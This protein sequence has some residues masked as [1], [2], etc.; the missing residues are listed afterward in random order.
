MTNTIYAAVEP[1]RCDSETGINTAIGC[2]PFNDTNALLTFLLRWFIGIGGGIAIFTIIFASYLIISSSG[3]PDRVKAGQQLI[4]AS[5]AGIIF[6][7]FSGFILQ[8]VGVTVF[9]IPGF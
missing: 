6:L 9:K 7:I 1:L 8:F 4:T 3:N 2:I 5:I